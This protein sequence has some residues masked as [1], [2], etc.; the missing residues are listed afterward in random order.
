VLNCWL[1]RRWIGA[2]LDG[3]LEGTRARL[4]GRHLEHCATCQGEAEALGRLRTMLRRTLAP[5]EPDW[6][7]FWPGI[8]RGVQDGRQ[9]EPARPRG[10]GWG[11]RWALGGA[12]AAAFVLTVGLWQTLDQGPG[13]NGAEPPTIVSSA[14][15]EHPGASVMVYSTPERDVAVV[16]VVGLRED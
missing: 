8:V 11:F 14:N 16:W 9:A 12:F 2:Y 3:A 13:F 6:T 15:S 7:G 10:A 4:A 5:A 1:T